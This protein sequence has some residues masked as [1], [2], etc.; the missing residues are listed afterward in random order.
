MSADYL[1]YNSYSKQYRPKLTK[2]YIYNE[3]Y[4]I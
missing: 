3:Q 4:V 2:I 1:P